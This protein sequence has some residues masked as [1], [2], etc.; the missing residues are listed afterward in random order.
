MLVAEYIVTTA[1]ILG[2]QLFYGQP[3]MATMLGLVSYTLLILAHSKLDRQVN[4]KRALG[5]LFFLNLGI[6]AYIV[7]RGVVGDVALAAPY[8][9]L[10]LVSTAVLVISRRIKLATI[11]TLL[12]AVVYLFSIPVNEKW[13]MF[14][15]GLITTLAVSHGYV[16]ILDTYN[17]RRGEPGPITLLRAFLSLW[18]DGDPTPLEGVLMRSAETMNFSMEVLWFKTSSGASAL[19]SLPFH[20][21]PL[22]NMGGSNI[23]GILMRRNVMCFHGPSSHETDIV[24]GRDRDRIVEAIVNSYS[25]DKELLTV[26]ASRMIE[27]KDGPVLAKGFRI[28]DVVIISVTASPNSMEDLDPEIALEALKI[29]RK[30]G[31]SSCIIIDS[32]NSLSGPPL[33]RETVKIHSLRAIANLT[34]QLSDEPL[35]EALIGFS[36]CDLPLKPHEGGGGGGVAVLA[37][38]AGQYTQVLV[39]VDGNNMVSGFRDELV[40]ELKTKLD[41]DSEIATTDTHEVTGLRPGRMGYSPIG[42]VKPDKVKSTILH[43]VER[44]LKSLRRSSYTLET[45]VVK[46]V[47]V[48]GR[49]LQRID[50][51]VDENIK[52]GKIFPYMAIAASI[53]AALLIHL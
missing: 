15:V 29:A 49:S 4:L 23:T 10:I 46:E 34:R 12:I 51:I 5:L 30:N 7:L 33:D 25:P 47:K 37:V 3:N 45:V 20:P 53:V 50:K 26:R 17:K 35:R 44:A 22:K 9:I 6:L 19:L 31:F 16:Y 41:V 52:W 28:G 32:H 36:R 27:V 40:E 8:A 42:E 1:L 21:G 11:S 13:P 18:L 39:L 2:L 14:L 38:K 48:L 43:C 24:L